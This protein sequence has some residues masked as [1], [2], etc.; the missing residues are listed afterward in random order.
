M[1]RLTHD[2]ACAAEQQIQAR[3]RY[4]FDPLPP[5][6]HQGLDALIRAGVAFVMANFAIFAAQTPQTTA[7][8]SLQIVAAGVETSEDAPFVP[9]TYHF[10]PGDYVYF[11]FQIAGYAVQTNENSE[12]RKISLTYDLTPQDNKGI[13]LTPALSGVIKEDLNAEDKN[14]TPKRRASFLLPSFIATGQFH[15]HVVVNDLI[16][17]KSTERDIPFQIGGTLVV[18][19]G[20][21]TVQDFQ[22]LRNEDDSEPLDVPA[23]SPGDTV[24]ARFLMTGFQLAAGN[25][26]HLSYGLT[27]SRPDGKP[28]LNQETAAEVSNRSFYPTP[29]VPGNIGITT[30]RT[31]AHGQY[32]LLLTVR[33]V[34]GSQTYQIKRAFTIE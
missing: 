9:A 31:A 15:L 27:V 12:V 2:R 21:L 33:D 14:W 3:R 18:P 26:Y 4:P 1:N 25:E 19:S 13:A 5:L 11:Q 32:V 16:G 10:L 17:H 34:I 24:Y 20:I 30:T 29:Y 28:Y 6:F 22:F 7:E 8:N 23:Y